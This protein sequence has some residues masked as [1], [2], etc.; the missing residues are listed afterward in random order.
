V[1]ESPTK[2]DA[3]PLDLIV[4]YPMTE[5]ANA[6]DRPGLYAWY[7][8]AAPGPQ[9]LATRE[10][11]RNYIALHTRR[12]TTPTLTLQA[13]STFRRSWAGSL[14]E[15]TS[16]QFDKL[17]GLSPEASEALEQGLP[18]SEDSD[19]N[20]DEL[21]GALNEVLADDGLRDVLIESLNNAIPLLTSP[22]YVGIAKDQTLRERL[23][24]HHRGFERLKRAHPTIDDRRRLLAELRAKGKSSFAA[25]ALASGFTADSLEVHCLPLP[26]EL[27]DDQGRNMLPAVEYLIN[28]WHYPPFGRR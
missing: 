21:R 28:R 22:L 6:P 3:T 20:P 4:R 7:G 10:A 19:L 1:P 27:D 17:L 8:R 14:N 9:D 16:I 12:F 25:H 26:P 13:K 2:P 5:V 11:V 24:S 15:T 18:P 23:R